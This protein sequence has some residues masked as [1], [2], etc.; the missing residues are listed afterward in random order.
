LSRFHLQEQYEAIFEALLEL[1]TVPD[2][3][4]PKKEFCQYISDQEQ[5]KLPQ[6]QKL[7]K[8]E[9]QRLETLRP[10]YPPSAFSAATS[11]DNISKNSTKKIF[12]HNRYR[13]YT[14]SHSGTRN[15][16]INAV[17]IPVSK[18]SVIIN[19]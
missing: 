3:S 14:M 8:L 1:F 13:P 19:L 10:V 15:D 16:Y 5:K 18:L 11:K 17:I 7:Y 12:P 6:N 9:F 2:T 4:I